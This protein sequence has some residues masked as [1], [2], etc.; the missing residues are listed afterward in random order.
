MSSLI[1]KDNALAKTFPTGI[2]IPTTSLAS[3]QIRSRIQKNRVANDGNYDE[4]DA[5]IPSR[6]PSATNHPYATNPLV[7]A[8]KNFPPQ[9]QCIVHNIFYLQGNTHSN[10][11][12]N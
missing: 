5:K 9:E 2:K 11:C 8:T 12:E 6:P 1:T 4:N 10:T 7:A 3:N